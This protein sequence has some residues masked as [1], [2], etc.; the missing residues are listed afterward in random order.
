MSWFSGSGNGAA[1]DVAE[2]LDGL[3]M[4]G[5]RE[6]IE[7][8]A[9]VSV[10]TTRDGGALG[11]TVTVD[12]EWRRDYFRQQDEMLLWIAEALP[13]VHEARGTQARPSAAPGG[14]SRRRK[15]R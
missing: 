11:V 2:M 12:G 5:I 4:Q 9:L 14:G 7:A 3:G 6:L 10:G 1:V 15:G 8:G 13:A